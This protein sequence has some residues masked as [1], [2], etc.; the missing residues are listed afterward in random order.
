MFI[1]KD[2]FPFVA[3]LEDNWRLIREECL[4]LLEQDYDPWVQDAMYDNGWKIYGLM[5]L[6]KRIPGHAEKCPRTT[7]ILSGIPGVTLAG[8][9]RMPLVRIMS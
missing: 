2:D 3:T 7:E 5:A 1:P 4:R 6:D 8:F 9:S